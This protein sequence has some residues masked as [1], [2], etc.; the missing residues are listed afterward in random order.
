MPPKY[1]ERAKSRIKGFLK[2]FP[3]VLAKAE[4]A[5]FN[6]SD[7]RTLV[8]EVL[9]TA[10]G[11]D[12]FFEI[13]SEFEIK[14]RY[15]DFAVK[16]ETNGRIWR[17]YH[18]TSGNP[19]DI[20][21]VFEVD[22]LQAKEDLTEATNRLYLL[23]KEAVWRDAISDFWEVAKATSPTAIAQC[24]LSEG[25]LDEIRKELYRTTKQRIDNQTIWEVL[26]TQIIKGNILSQIIIPSKK[27]RS[28][29]K[30]VKKKSL[31]ATCFAY[32]PDPNKPSTWKLRYRNPDGSVSPS[33]LAGA[34]AA[35]SP[36]GF[37]GKKVN[38]PEK[39]LPKVKE[40]LLNA[41]FEIGTPEK[42]IP[43]G[44]K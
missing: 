31:P 37:R 19:P 7:T 8:Q 22:L 3:D 28:S 29:K 30:E 15:A 9:N 20:E 17:C 18:L 40:T 36:G 44:I 41:Y 42:N 32:V 5:G 35:L 6:E 23:S 43:P 16:L 25:V 14:G 38:I 21:I 39:D 27:A 24:L 12:K 1:E 2:R 11:Y 34:V 13:T 4:D 26:T 10:L 33:H